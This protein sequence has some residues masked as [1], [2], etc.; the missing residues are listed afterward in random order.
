MEKSNMNI[1]VCLDDTDNLESRG[2][3]ELAS[4]LAAEI[5]E[6]RWGRSSFITRHQLLV[7][8]DIPYT[9]HNSAMCFAAVLEDCPPQRLIDHAARFLERESAPGSDP[10]L[11]VVVSD[12]LREPQRLVAFGRAAKEEVLSKEAAYL[13]A[14]DLNIHLSEHGGT[15]QGVVGALAGAGLRLGGNDGRLK[16]R[17]NLG[18]QGESVMAGELRAHPLVDEVR[19]TEGIAPEDRDLVRIG[20]KVKTV[21]LAGKSVLLLDREENPGGNVLWRTCSRQRL[22]NY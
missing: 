18:P 16:G 12:G 14:D 19:S 8:E 6:N 11:C 20:E 3:G 17:L 1:L 15:G 21:L 10:G 9:S 2:T 5:E 4:L 13:L 22:K 7:H